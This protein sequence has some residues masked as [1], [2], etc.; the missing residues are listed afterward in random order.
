MPKTVATRSNLGD[1]HETPVERADQH[2]YCSEQ[3]IF[4]IIVH[5][6]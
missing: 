1:C 2:E 3:S 4:F 6:L 5:L